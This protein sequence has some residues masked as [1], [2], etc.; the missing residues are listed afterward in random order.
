MVFWFFK[1]KC[2]LGDYYAREFHRFPPI[3]SSGD[4]NCAVGWCFLIKFLFFFSLSA[5]HKTIKQ[6]KTKIRRP[7][8]QSALL[9][10]EISQPLDA[11]A[12]WKG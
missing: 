10:G 9:S 5:G 2:T 8:T 7:N 1:K 4:L 6:K 3:G 11:T 12:C